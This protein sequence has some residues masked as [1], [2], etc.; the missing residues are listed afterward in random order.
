MRMHGPGLRGNITYIAYISFH[1]DPA[2]EHAKVDEAMQTLMYIELNLASK[3]PNKESVDKSGT[4]LS[5]KLS[6]LKD[7][8]HYLGETPGILPDTATAD[9]KLLTVA[10][11]AGKSGTTTTEEDCQEDLDRAR[12]TDQLA[13]WAS[14]E[15]RV[16]KKTPMAFSIFTVKEF[17]TVMKHMKAKVEAREKRL[18]Q[19]VTA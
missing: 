9:L 12:L 14:L 4:V 1:A 3:P 10:F 17:S 18:A 19:S 7:F 8:T 6:E 11:S 13:A 15:Q 2:V 5:G 16:S